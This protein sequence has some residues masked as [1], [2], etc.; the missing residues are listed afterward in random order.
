MVY[1]VFIKP[2][3]RKSPREKDVQGG[4]NKRPDQVPCGIYLLRRVQTK[5]QRRET[6]GNSGRA[7]KR[8]RL[9]AEILG[10]REQNWLF[11]ICAQ[12][13]RPHKHTHTR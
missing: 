12:Q 3:I 2:K 8:R 4:S 6:T 7:K 5:Q 11:K 13:P 10:R 9:E 1:L